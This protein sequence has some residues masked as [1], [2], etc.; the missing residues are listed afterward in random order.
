MFWVV[1]PNTT[2]AASDQ[3]FLKSPTTSHIGF[4]NS[5]FRLA[6]LRI[7]R[8]PF[9]GAEASPSP[10]SFLMGQLGGTR[11]GGAIKSNRLRLLV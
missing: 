6:G 1:Y 5:A 9:G 7:F 10:K 2:E 11:F 8:H 3:P 4:E